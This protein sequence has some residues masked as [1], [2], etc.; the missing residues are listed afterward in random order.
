MFRQAGQRHQH[1]NKGNRLNT[2]VID[3]IMRSNGPDS[4]IRGQQAQWLGVGKLGA[5][6]WNLFPPASFN[7]DVAICHNELAKIKRKLRP[8]WSCHHNQCS[9]Q[10]MLQALALTSRPAIVA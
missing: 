1:R 8:V 2:S 5:C 6:Q 10:S 7:G 3:T 4:N 9:L